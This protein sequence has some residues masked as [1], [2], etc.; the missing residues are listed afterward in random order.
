MF[1]DVHESSLGRPS[2][3]FLLI[4]RRWVVSI[5]KNLDPDGPDGLPGRVLRECAA[6]LATPIC[7]IARGILMHGV[8]PEI[9]KMH[10]P[11]VQARRR[12]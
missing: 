12:S 3:K 8:W 5:L 9:L 6:E 4:R 2:P 11:L 7:I 10:P 1:S